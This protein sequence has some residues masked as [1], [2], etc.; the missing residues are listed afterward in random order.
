MSAN[1]HQQI[2]DALRWYCR[3]IDRL[4][5]DAVARAFHPGAILIDYRPHPLTIESFIANVLPSLEARFIATQH[6]ISNTLATFADDDRNALVETY[7]LAFHV[8]AAAVAG[9]A[10]DQ[11]HTFNGRYID[12]FTEVDGEWRIAERT[13]RCDWSR[14]EPIDTPMRS[15]WPASG[16]AGSPDPLDD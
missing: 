13:L 3:G 5:G 1:A 10:V 7:V 14:I 15:I 11:L 4:D 9:A 8:E 12:R 2:D 6:R 16:R